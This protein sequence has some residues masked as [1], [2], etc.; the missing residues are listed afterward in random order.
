MSNQNSVRG[1]RNPYNAALKAASSAAL[2][3]TLLSDSAEQ[4]FAVLY[5]DDKGEVSGSEKLS[6]TTY[7]EPASF[8]IFRAAL[9]A[10]ASSLVLGHNSP[11]NNLKPTDDDWSFTSQIVNG[12]VGVGISV[13]DHIIVGSNAEKFNSMRGEVNASD[14]QLVQ[15]VMSLIDNLGPEKKA[16]A[17]ELMKSYGLNPEDYLSSDQGR[18]TTGYDSSPLSGLASINLG[19]KPI[20]S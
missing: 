13:E 2:L 16:Q 8:E 19:K 14:D 1:A 12:G 11:T 18:S 17:R 20:L 10:G 15:T 9:K 5:L 4:S 6:F 7:G 3:S